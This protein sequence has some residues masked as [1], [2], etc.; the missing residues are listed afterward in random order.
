MAFGL[1]IRIYER[2]F[3]DSAFQKI[4]NGY[5]LVLVTTTTIGYGDMYPISHMGRFIAIVACVVGMVLVSLFVV[6]LNTT[7]ALDENEDKAYSAVADRLYKKSHLRKD[8]I[9]LL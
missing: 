9:S 4:W 5:W 8:A 6:A 7:M 1:L 2:V 3:E